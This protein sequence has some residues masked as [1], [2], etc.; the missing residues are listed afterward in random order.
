MSLIETLK[1]EIKT[2]M[3]ARDDVKKNVLRV[4]LGDIQMEETRKGTCS[5][6]TAETILRKLFAANVETIAAC[7]D[8][9]RNEQLTRENEILDALLP[10]QWSVEE[11][12]TFLGEQPGVID[13]IQGANADG[14]ATGMAMGA[15][16]PSGAPVN[17]KDVA[18]AVAQIRNG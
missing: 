8:S 2:A 1:A 6:E 15:L 17:G 11:I 13:R 16:K 5:E 12:I 9:P 4:A 18:A 10:K 14:P 7:P 3:K